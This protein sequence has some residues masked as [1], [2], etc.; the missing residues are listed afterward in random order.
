MKGTIIGFGLSIGLLLV[1]LCAAPPTGLSMEGFRTLCLTLV[2]VVLWCAEVVP[3]TVTAVLLVVAIP[4]LGI[5]TAKQAFAASGSSAFFFLIAAFGICAGLL[6]TKIPQRLMSFVFR[7]T[8]NDSKRIIA[9]YILVSRPGVRHGHRCRCHGDLRGPGRRHAE[10]HREP[11]TRHEPDGQ[12]PDDRDSL[13]G[14][15]RRYLPPPPPTPSTSSP[16]RC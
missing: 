11:R 3:V 15:H 16:S 2:A 5:E 14:A 12:G 10:S 6:Q 13:R 1:A 4:A 9:G 8:G 7:Q